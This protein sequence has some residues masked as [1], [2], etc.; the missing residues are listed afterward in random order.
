MRVLRQLHGFAQRHMRRTLQTSPQLALR[1]M[2][3]ALFLLELK[4]H[5]TYSLKRWLVG[6]FPRQSKPAIS[7]EI[8]QA[9]R[10]TKRVEQQIRLCQ[11]NNNTDLARS[12]LRFLESLGHGFLANRRMD[13]GEL[14]FTTV[15]NYLNPNSPEG[16]LNL[17]HLG[18][19][20]FMRGY[21]GQAKAT[22]EQEG[23][24]HRYLQQSSRI[25]PPFRVLGRSWFAAI[26]HVAMID[27]LLKKRELGWYG[28]VERFVVEQ[29][30]SNIPG[31][32]ILGYFGEHGV[33]LAW[34][35]SL[36]S[37]YDA[38]RSETDPDWS[39]LRSCEI[40]GLTDGYWQFFFPDGDIKFYAHACAKIQNEWERRQ[41]PPLLALSQA[42]RA[43]AD[44]ILQMLGVPKNTWYVCLHVRETGFHKKWNQAY[45]SSRDANVEDYY[46]AIQAIVERGG[47]VIRM[48]DDSMK[49]LRPMPGVVDYVHTKYKSEEVD[50]L[51]SAGCRFMLGTNSGYSILPA[52]YGVPCVLTNW[53]PISLPNWYGIDLM[54]PKLM[55]S[56]SS[57]ELLDFEAMFT[58]PIGVI[59]F[60]ADYPKDLEIIENTPDE[61]RAVTVEMLDRLDGATYSKADD[62]LQARYFELALRKGSY[63]GSRIGRDFLANYS[64]L[65]P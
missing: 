45:P 21:V 33:D 14:F 34:P 42:Q 19:T 65:L 50:M 61:I 43:A 58:D 29:D 36:E 60:V 16:M 8:E 55:R 46:L 41:L 17:R 53:V 15:A 31:K 48:G 64:H 5:A 2:R 47:W 32:V 28:N 26:G 22:F 25:S 11:K 27:F 23:L 12:W 63:R 51:L 6:C 49:P 13:L 9:I 54:I 20:Q 39:E 44:T 24:A 59:Q 10:T 38:Y 7:L 18:I 40:E 1:G 3:V 52:T 37:Y 30:V 56:K 57:G 4:Y 35:D 62:L